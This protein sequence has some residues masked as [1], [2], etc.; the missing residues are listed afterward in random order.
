[1]YPRRGVLRH[2]IGQ[3]AINAARPVVR[4]VHPGSRNRLIDVKQVFALAEAI[5]KHRHGAQIQTMTP[6]T[7]QVRKDA[8]DL[9][10]HHTDIL[11]AQRHLYA[12]KFFNRQHVGMLIAHHGAI[13]QT[14]HIWHRLQEGPMLGQL[15]RRAMQQPDM[16]VGTHNRFPVQL[17]HQ[18][19]N[20]VSSRM[21]RPKIH[22]VIADISHA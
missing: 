11:S 9:I 8:G 10:K 2:G 1:M 20:A 16:R 21:L 6:Q 4:R 13:I 19:Q 7:Q 12:Q 15:F 17:Q 5:Q 18:T 22:C 14:I 3:I